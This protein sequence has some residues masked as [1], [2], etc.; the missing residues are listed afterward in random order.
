MALITATLARTQTPELRHDEPQRFPHVSTNATT[1][2]QSVT[3]H[4]YC[5]LANMD[6]AWP[7]SANLRD[8]LVL[9]HLGHTKATNVGPHR[10]TEPVHNSAP[11]GRVV[12]RDDRSGSGTSVRNRH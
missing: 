9:A 8:D 4:N 1:D 6:T 7:T 2:P 12:H 5:E 3:T 10:V 11:L